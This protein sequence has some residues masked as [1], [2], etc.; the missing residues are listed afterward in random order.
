MVE[1]MHRGTTITS[2]V[3]SETLKKLHRVGHSEQK[4]WNADILCSAAP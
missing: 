2:E 4:S 3:H 1:I